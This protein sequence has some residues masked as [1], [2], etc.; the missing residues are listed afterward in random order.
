M[1]A[2]AIFLSYARDDA[3]AARRVAEA[4]RSSGVEV[5]FDENELRGGDEWDRK[6]RKQIDECTLFVPLISRHTEARAKGYFRLEWKL[7]VDQMQMMAAGVPFIAPVAIDDTRETGAVVPPEFLRV[8]W[9]RLPGALPTPEFVAQ[10]K[11]LLE[12]PKV[13]PVDPGV[14]RA[15]QPV[16]SENTGWK[17]RATK[18]R[19][20]AAVWIGAIAVV[21]IGV[22][23]TF[24]ATRK[25]EPNAGAG[26]R[27]PT[28]EKSATP[29]PPSEARQLVAKA[30][31]LYEPW[32]LARREDFSLAEQLLKKAV[33][34]DPTDGEAWAAYAILSC[35]M[36]GLLHDPSAERIS[37]ARTQAEN[38]LKFAPDSGQARFARAFSLW[39]NPATRDES[40]RLLRAEAGRQPTN[41]VVVR[42]TGNALRRSSQHEQAL[43]YLD[44]AVALPGSDPVSQHNRAESLFS[45]GRFDEAE[46]AWDE[47]LALAPQIINA[48]RGK[49]NL[50]LEVRGDL[51]RAQAH[52][53]KVPP[54][55]FL[56]ARGAYLA[57]T[58]AL[59]ARDHGKCL[60]YLRHANDY[61]PG[62][63]P[64]AALTAVAHRL[65]GNAEAAR[66][67]FQAAL[68]LVNDR[69]AAEP[70]SIALLAHRAAILIELGDRAVA[71]PLVREIRQRV[72]AGDSTLGA[73]RRS[74]AQLL[75]GLGDHEGALA[76]LESAR[77]SELFA[78]QG[79][80]SLRHHPVWEPLRGN[81]RFEALLKSAMPKK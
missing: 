3:A 21:V 69:L 33:E 53:A 19:I 43:V 55:F 11:R 47:A 9:M 30:R 72:N 38:A 80:T 64:K 73:P 23:A 26:T 17:A 77:P 2:P 13:A 52:L 70:N 71:E 29:A 65:A 81:P 14:A 36:S 25:G 1:S 40:I 39:L 22:A 62:V 16:G 46:V 66:T 5:W 32:D 37:A 6:I 79:S 49:L 8:Q 75:A 56:D 74:V 10:M 63:G 27:P 54:D 78:A 57:Y 60:E 20:P 48:H 12:A 44:R 76:T 51:A 24:L 7:A 15:F 59:Y 50:L 58:V 18:T 31:A 45:L 34:L 28:T 4:L 68:R 67:D 35:G 41:R 61:I 42:V